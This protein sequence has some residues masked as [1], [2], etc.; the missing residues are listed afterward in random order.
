VA[1]PRVDRGLQEHGATRAA[2]YSSTLTQTTRDFA[3]VPV[4]APHQSSQPGLQ[5]STTLAKPAETRPAPSLPRENAADG[6][7]PIVHEVLSSPG[8]PLDPAPRS[9]FESRFGRDFSHVRIH[10]DVKSIESTK[11]INSSAYAMGPH[12]V[13]GSEQHLLGSASGN[14]LIAHELTHVVQLRVGRGTQSNWDRS[15]ARRP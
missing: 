2:P 10:T 13:L 11:A 8:K 6:V 9:Y 3:G 15:G 4:F 5:R 7:P 14:R 12:V 1:G